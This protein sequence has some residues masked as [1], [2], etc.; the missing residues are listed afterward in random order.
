MPFR[1]D[2]SSPS[3]GF[4]TGLTLRPGRWRRYV[5]PKRWT[6]SHLYALTTQKTAF[7]IL[8]SRRTSSPVFLLFSLALQPN[9]GLGRLHKTFRFT[10]VTRSWTAGRTPW[11]GD[12]LVARPL[13]VH[14]HR[15]THTQH[16]H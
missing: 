15:K 14:K 1:K 4:P 12:Q 8:T 5:P 11:T 7:F 10:S 6:V 2:L 16:K 13:P 3:A 9:S